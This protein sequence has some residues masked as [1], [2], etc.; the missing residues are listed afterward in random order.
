M[1]KT[2]CKII[3]G[4]PT[5]LVVKGLMMVM[6]MMTMMMMMMVNRRHYRATA[7]AHVKDPVVHVSVRWIMETKTSSMH[8]MLDNVTLSQ[9]AFPGESNSNFQWKKSQ[10][11]NTVV[12]NKQTHTQTKTKANYTVTCDL[13]TCIFSFDM[14]FAVV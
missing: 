13:A 9:L 14:T 10:W 5:T 12:E 4:I 7:V 2:G 11:G 1:E 8:R 6:M 3:C